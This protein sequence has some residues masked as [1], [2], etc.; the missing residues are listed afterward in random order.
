MVYKVIAYPIGTIFG[1]EAEEIDT[2]DTWFDYE[3]PTLDE[4]KFPQGEDHV[5]EVFTRKATKREAIEY[6][7]KLF[8]IVTSAGHKED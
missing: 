8:A 1:W 4:V 2:Y 5:A 3:K 7:I 6:A